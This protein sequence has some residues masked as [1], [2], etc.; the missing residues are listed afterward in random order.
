MNSSLRDDRDGLILFSSFGG[1]VSFSF[2]FPNRRKG[3]LS[4]RRLDLVVVEF[5]VRL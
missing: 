4:N 5:P 1:V 3:P 2:F